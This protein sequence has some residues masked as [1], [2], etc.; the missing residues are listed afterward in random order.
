MNLNNI[1]IAKGTL[2]DNVYAGFFDIHN[3]CWRKKVNV[4]DDFLATVISRFKGATETITCSDTSIYKITVEEIRGP[5]Q[6]V[7]SA[8]E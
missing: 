4:T 6:E 1:R 2:T 5:A 7:S 8:K 3:N